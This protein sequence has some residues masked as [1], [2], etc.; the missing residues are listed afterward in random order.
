MRPRGAQLEPRPLRRARGIT[1]K[2]S[3][4]RNPLRSS[5]L[6]QF[7]VFAPLPS[8]VIP[9]RR[10]TVP[11]PSPGDCSA[12]GHNHIAPQPLLVAAS[13]APALEQLAASLLQVGIAKPVPRL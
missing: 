12:P 7:G 1:V 9:I 13:I 3:A 2:L 11:A 4:E 6:A 5:F 8:R 10:E